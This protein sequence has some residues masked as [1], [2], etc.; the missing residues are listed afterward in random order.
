MFR[1]PYGYGRGGQPLFVRSRG[2]PL[3]PR[4]YPY[5]SNY[6]QTYE[7]DEYAEEDVYDH[8]YDDAG[9][10]RMYGQEDEYEQEEDDQYENFDQDEEDDQEYEEED[11][12]SQFLANISEKSSYF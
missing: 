10:N 9:Y 7:E 4:E 1:R 11:D 5:R 8:S 3:P 12:V 2:R 6:R